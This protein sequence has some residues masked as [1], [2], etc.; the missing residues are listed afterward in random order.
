M[1]GAKEVDWINL[2]WELVTQ[3]LGKAQCVKQLRV[4]L[5]VELSDWP[6]S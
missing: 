2:G 3:I 5:R 6:R 4:L 1:A